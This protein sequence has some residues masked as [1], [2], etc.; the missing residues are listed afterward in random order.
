[1]AYI[2]HLHTILNINHSFPLLAL[3]NALKKQNPLA[4]V[5]GSIDQ[6]RIINKY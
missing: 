6:L 1:M 2:F 3:G 5:T 4:E